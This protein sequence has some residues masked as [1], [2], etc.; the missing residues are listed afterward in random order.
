MNAIKSFSEKI[1]DMLEPEEGGD[2]VD[3]SAARVMRDAAKLPDG[4]KVADLSAEE[5]ATALIELRV[6]GTARG[7]TRKANLCCYAV[8]LRAIADEAGQEAVSLWRLLNDGGNSQE[9]DNDDDDEK[10]R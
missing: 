9:E 10:S 6:P 7:N 8:T 1:R 3:I 5:L 4:R 2:A